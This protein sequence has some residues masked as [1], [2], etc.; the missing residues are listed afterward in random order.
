MEVYPR[1]PVDGEDFQRNRKV[2]LLKVLD[3]LD[4]KVG[5]EGVDG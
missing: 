4:E 2:S 1:L 3:Q 5:R